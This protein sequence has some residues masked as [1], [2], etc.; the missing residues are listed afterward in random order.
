LGDA[1]NLNVEQTMM[2]RPQALMTSG[3]NQ[4]DPNIT[5]IS[6][7]GIPV[8]FNNEWMENTLLGRAEWIRFVG[9]FFG[10]EAEAD[11]IFSFIAE[12]YH[13]I[14]KLATQVES[15]PT[16]MSGSNFRGTWYMPGGNSFMSRL[17][18][19]AGASYFYADNTSSGSLPLSVETVIMNFSQTDFWLDSR[20][21][22][23]A[24]LLRADPHHALF[25]P[26]QIGAVYNFN[27][28]TLPTG[29]N[30]FWES[31]V[32]RPDL[33]LADVIAI[34]HPH[35]LPGH[36]LVYAKRLE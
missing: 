16:V 26:V 19:D 33:V 17:F 8:I 11:S 6:R 27:R 34:L 14:K 4:N 24:E 36:E 12:N 23:I 29:A 2:L 31:G 30:D 22:S 35:I 3:F 28:R 1:F 32:A 7:A 18:A 5:R 25:R 20:F 9:A 21:N 15:H 13:A 10:K